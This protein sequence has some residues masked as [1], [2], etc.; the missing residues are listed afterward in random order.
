MIEK[1]TLECISSLRNNQTKLIMLV[2]PT[3]TLN[4]C[5][6]IAKS[7][8]FH[9]PVIDSDAKDFNSNDAIFLNFD[10]NLCGQKQLEILLS[11]PLI[12]I[13]FGKSE[14]SSSLMLLELVRASQS[15]GDC[16]AVYGNSE[17][18]LGPMSQANLSLGPSSCSEKLEK[19]V[20]I[21]NPQSKSLN[22]FLVALDLGIKKKI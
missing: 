12:F 4:F 18:F 14:N 21:F 1:Q 19:V 22:H 9:K 3:W 11:S 7:M 20:D 6:S 16:V 5:N 15:R 2:E 10:L 13:R 8:G 17:I